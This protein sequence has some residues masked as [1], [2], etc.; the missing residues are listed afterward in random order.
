MA[1]ALNGLKPLMDRLLAAAG[2]AGARYGVAGNTFV[3]TTTPGPS[4][5]QLAAGRPQPIGSLTGAVTGIIRAAV[6]R[7]TLIDRLGLPP[8]A[9]IALGALGDA[10]FS[11]RTATTGVEATADVSIR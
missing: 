11:V 6:L 1:R 3:V 7:Q 8:I 9:S 2:L 5:A 10:T 4:L